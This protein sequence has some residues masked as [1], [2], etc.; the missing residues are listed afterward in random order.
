MRTDRAL[1]VRTLAE[2]FFNLT[3]D[4]EKTSAPLVDWTINLTL[5]ASARAAEMMFITAFDSDC[6]NLLKQIKTS[7]FILHGDKDVSCPPALTAVPTHTMLV[8]STLKVYKDFAHGMYINKAA[9]L[10]KDIITFIKR[11]KYCMQEQLNTEEHF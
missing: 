1:Y 4:H 10:S 11:D 5:Q 3:D 9:V 8:N 7:V 6:R 2:G